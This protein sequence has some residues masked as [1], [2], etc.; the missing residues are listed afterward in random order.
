[1]AAARDE[2]ELEMHLATYLQVA[3]QSVLL[4]N[5]YGS[6]C[7]PVHKR[8]SLL[9]HGLLSLQDLLRVQDVEEVDGHVERDRDVLPH[10]VGHFI[11][12]VDH[13]VLTRKEEKK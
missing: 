6:R 5:L 10:G 9:H 2:E 11:L 4:F 7:L 12:R 3:G 1:M 13:C 8:S